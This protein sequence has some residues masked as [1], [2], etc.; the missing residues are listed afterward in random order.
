MSMVRFVGHNHPCREQDQVETTMNNFHMKIN[1][2][3][4]ITGPPLFWILIIT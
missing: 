1:K 2:A 3:S 4:M